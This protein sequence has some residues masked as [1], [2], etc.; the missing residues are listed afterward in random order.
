MNGGTYL[1]ESAYLPMD[2]T[3]QLRG[4]LPQGAQRLDLQ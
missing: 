4:L 2:N 1:G 3:L